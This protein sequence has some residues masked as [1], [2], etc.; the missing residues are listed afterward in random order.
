MAC[1]YKVGREG[2]GVGEQW[3]KAAWKH[4]PTPLLAFSPISLPPFSNPTLCM[5]KHQILLW[6]WRQQQQQQ[7]AAQRGEKG[8]LHPE[9][10]GVLD[11]MSLLQ[12]DFRENDLGAIFLGIGL[13]DVTV[14]KEELWSVDSSATSQGC[15][16]D[17][18][19]LAPYSGRPGAAKPLFVDF[20]T[21]TNS[22][23]ELF[24]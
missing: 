11:L 21:V 7:T 16:E 24:P 15:E 19:F 2:T 4:H 6:L 3:R 22:T 18:T 20:C 12:W 14:Y 10:P 17:K 1:I 9:L 8:Q 23:G 5:Y 13:A